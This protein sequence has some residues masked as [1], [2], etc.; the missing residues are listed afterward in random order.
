MDKWLWVIP[1]GCLTFSDVHKVTTYLS[2]FTLYCT[3]VYFFL[4]V[5]CGRVRLCLTGKQH[6][7]HSHKIIM[8]LVFKVE[9]DLNWE[10]TFCFIMSVFWTNLIVPVKTRWSKVSCISIKL[11]SLAYL[12]LLLDHILTVWSLSP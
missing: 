7:D 10:Q 3:A 6:N 12:T 2:C 8:C 4:C 9:F 11:L 5:V 1:P